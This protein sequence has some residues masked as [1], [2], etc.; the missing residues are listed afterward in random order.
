MSYSY[1]SDKLC[2]NSWISKAKTIALKQYV[3]KKGSLYFANTWIGLDSSSYDLKSYTS[4]VGILFCFV[5]LIFRKQDPYEQ[6]F[7]DLG[8]TFI[9]ELKFMW[10]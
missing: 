3:F 5:S 9:E 2:V 6:F 1:Y 8:L 10:V 7:N 4:H